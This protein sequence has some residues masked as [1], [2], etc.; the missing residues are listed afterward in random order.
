[1]TRRL[2]FVLVLVAPALAPASRA[3]ADTAAV[4]VCAGVGLAHTATPLYYPPGPVKQTS[5][6][7]TFITQSGGCVAT[8]SLDLATCAGGVGVDN[9]P[10]SLTPVNPASCQYPGPGETD[11]Y[12]SFGSA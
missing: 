10:V 9:T 8:G 12:I 4:P 5:Y 3:A 2:L 1:M 7:A 11:F 6:Y